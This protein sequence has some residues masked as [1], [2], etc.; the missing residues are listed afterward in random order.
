VIGRSEH[1]PTCCC[2]R[3]VKACSP[4][5]SVFRNALERDIDR[6]SPAAS[7]AAAHTARVEVAHF[8][9]F[10]PAGALAFFGGLQN[11]PQ[12]LLVFVRQHRKRAPPSTPA[13]RIALHPAAHRELEKSSQ[14][15]QLLSKSPYRIPIAGHRC[16]AEARTSTSAKTAPQPT[17]AIKKHTAKRIVSSCSLLNHTDRPSKSIAIYDVH[18]RQGRAERHAGFA[19]ALKDSVH[20]VG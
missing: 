19:A 12:R 8:L 18:H 7:I 6:F 4:A 14:G 11:L 9:S 17:I 13:D 2:S 10:E 15:L 3:A 16:R 5:H 1:T 20:G